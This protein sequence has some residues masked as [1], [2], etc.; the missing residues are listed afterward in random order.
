MLGKRLQ[1]C[2]TP[3]GGGPIRELIR[4]NVDRVDGLPDRPGLVATA[5]FG[6]IGSKQLIDSAE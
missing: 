1:G 2:A 5:P 6:I 3:L 4:W